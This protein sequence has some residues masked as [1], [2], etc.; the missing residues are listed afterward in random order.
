MDQE[1]ASAVERQKPQLRTS[2]VGLKSDLLGLLMGW[3]AVKIAMMR[4]S[5][6]FDRARCTSRRSKF[7]NPVSG[8]HHPE[9]PIVPFYWSQFL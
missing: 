7:L 5:L 1:L 9:H 6:N 4:S 3:S 8:R 2:H